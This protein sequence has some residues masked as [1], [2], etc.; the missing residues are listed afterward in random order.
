MKDKA[1]A[2]GVLLV[3]IVMLGAACSVLPQGSWTVV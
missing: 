1:W 3:A 2:I